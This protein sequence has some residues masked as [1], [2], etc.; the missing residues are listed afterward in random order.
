ME[1]SRSG[2][3]RERVWA[4]LKAKVG[5]A[6]RRGASWVR[7]LDRVRALGSSEGRSLLWTRLRHRERLHQTSGYTE[8]ER[9]PELF[10]RCA[11]LRPD[12]GRILS[13]GCSTGEELEAIRRRWRHARIVGAE[14]NPR[15]RRIA[16]RRLAHDPA[17][18][19]VTP[20]AIDG[21]FDVVFALAVLQVQP[22][23]VADQ[24]IADLSP[25]Y[26]FARFD[27]QV[28]RLVAMLAPGG[29]LCVMHA[30]YRIE[31]SR[32]AALLE[33]LHDSPALDPPIF[34]S[35]GRRLGNGAVGRSLFRR[36]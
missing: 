19:V 25:I 16:A 33:R 12:A 20:E 32:A 11:A 34:G 6:R 2:Q 4:A 23:R 36:R 3:S 30:H 1:D 27:K 7:L 24:G 28:E 26:P 29:L 21:A 31:D 9:Y 14:I 13:F 35:D 18:C 22:H 8:A 10:D 15:S 5:A 17:I